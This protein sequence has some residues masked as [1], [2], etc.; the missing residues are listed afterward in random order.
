MLP[1]VSP[2]FFQ[3]IGHCLH[4]QQSAQCLFVHRPHLPYTGILYFGS[5]PI[6]NYFLIF[7]VI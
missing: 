3:R 5:F 4:L 1:Q 6:F 2:A 7:Y